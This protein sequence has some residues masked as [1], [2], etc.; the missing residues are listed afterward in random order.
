LGRLAL[1]G[2]AV[3][4]GAILFIIVAAEPF[5]AANKFLDVTHHQPSVRRFNLMLR[6]IRAQALDCANKFAPTT[7]STAEF[8]FM[9]I[10]L[11]L[12]FG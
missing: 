4:E 3:E 10:F 8:K 7:T 1:L 5:E 11:G 9:G 2:E 6:F 12:N